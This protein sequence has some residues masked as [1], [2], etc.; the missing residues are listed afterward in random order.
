MRTDGW[1]VLS[2]S[3][4][5]SVH[6]LSFFLFEFAKFEFQILSFVT[7]AVVSRL[8][9]FISPLLLVLKHKDIDPVVVLVETATLQL[10]TM[11]YA[12]RSHHK[13]ATASSLERL[14]P[15][16]MTNVLGFVDLAVRVRLASCSTILRQ[17]I[18]K[19][20]RGLWIKI[21]FSELS[22]SQQRLTDEMLASLL[23]RVDARHV[24]ENL[25][26]FCCEEIQGTGLAPLR[27]SRVLEYIDLR[28]CNH[29]NEDDLAVTV[30]ILRTM[31]P[32]KLFWVNFSL[33][34]TNSK[35]HN[36]FRCDLRAAR[37]KQ[38]H[39]QNVLC[40]ECQTPVSDPSRQ[41]VARDT[42]MPPTRCGDCRAHF[43]R[44]ESCS[45][46]VTDCTACGD[47]SCDK[48]NRIENCDTCNRALCERCSN[49][50][51][52][53]DC[54]EACCFD[55]RLSGMCSYCYKLLCER[56]NIIQGSPI[57]CCSTCYEFFCIDCR[58]V[59]LCVM[60]N[61]G[62]MCKECAG[63]KS[64]DHCG[65]MFCGNCREVN[66]IEGCSVE[67]SGHDVSS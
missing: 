9:S 10:C 5:L 54:K 19:D 28:G 51:A 60:C 33:N 24:T 11:L 6:L 23:T 16:I 59:D 34:E 1:T 14:P 35:A 12:T 8:F 17:L 44:L 38:A 61:D 57:L 30:Q 52:C 32:Y 62:T 36:R 48:C 37:L 21:D 53:D 64:C 42:G 39:D 55:C 27:H 2:V 22:Y 18:F 15:E 4:L 3:V 46:A 41:L 13:R 29:Q 25:S 58:K 20:C 26:L 65:G 63:M 49:I 50:F 56:C 47:S 66:F 43:C 67:I 40:S 7:L 31:I 45:V